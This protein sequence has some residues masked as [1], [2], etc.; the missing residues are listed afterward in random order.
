[1]YISHDCEARSLYA[2]FQLFFVT[3]DMHRPLLGQG[4]K[5]IWLNWPVINEKF[6]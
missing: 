3:S 6:A 2:D 5:S 1:L 4:A